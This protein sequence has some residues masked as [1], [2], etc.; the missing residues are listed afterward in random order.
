MFKFKNF[1]G[2]HEY[3][4]TL[5]DVLSDNWGNKDNNTQHDHTK[6]VPLENYKHLFTSNSHPS[7]AGHEKISHWL[8]DQLIINKWI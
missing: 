3:G 5:I 2:L 1:I 6:W 8:H 7:L 4:N